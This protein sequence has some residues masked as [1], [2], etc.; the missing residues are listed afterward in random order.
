MAATDAKQMR[1]VLRRHD[2]GVAAWADIG[3]TRIMKT[4]LFYFRQGE[5]WGVSCVST[6]KIR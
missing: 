4:E 6:F 1:T 5:M 2:W 3:E